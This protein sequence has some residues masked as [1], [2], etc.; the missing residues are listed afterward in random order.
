MNIVRMALPQPCAGDPDKLGLLMKVGD[1]V[2]AA[3]SH[4]GAD[5]ADE[6]VDRFAERTLERHAR[7]DPFG[8]EFVDVDLAFLEI[9]VGRTRSGTIFLLSSWK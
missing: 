9:A 3:V 4:A 5:A 2:A 6:L 8:N 7:H 1:G